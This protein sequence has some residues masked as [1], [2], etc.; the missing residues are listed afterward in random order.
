MLWEPLLF[1]NQNKNTAKYLKH[2]LKV[3]FNEQ[4]A[5]DT[6]R[7]CL[8]EAVRIWIYLPNF[9]SNQNWLLRI[10]ESFLGSENRGRK[11]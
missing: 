3:L 6:T 11:W 5:L 10:K 1:A 4:C 2:T 8:E 7:L 9:K